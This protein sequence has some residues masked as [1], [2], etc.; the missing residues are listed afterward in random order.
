MTVQ[1]FRN[2]EEYAICMR[3]IKRYKKGFEFTINYAQIP[4]GKANA[5]KIV[6]HDAVKQG[7]LENIA[8]GW[9]FEG[10][11]VEETYRKITEIE[12]SK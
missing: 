10:H 11:I 12:G 7:I 5:L 1:D 9:S 4:T 8:D 2:C 3:K 6:F